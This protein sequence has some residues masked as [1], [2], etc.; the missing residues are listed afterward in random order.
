MKELVRQLAQA[1]THM[2]ED[3]KQPYRLM[4]DI[5]KLRLDLEMK[6]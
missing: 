4:H 5:D 2:S 1:W 3:E 6:K